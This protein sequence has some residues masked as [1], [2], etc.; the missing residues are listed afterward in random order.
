MHDLG[1]EPSDETKKMLEKVKKNV[2]PQKDVIH[3]MMRF[4]VRAITGV[5]FYWI[6]DMIRNI[7]SKKYKELIP[8]IPKEA[9]ETLA[10][11]QYRCGGTHGE[12]SDA[13][14]IDAVLTFVMLACSGG[15]SIGITIG[16]PEA[17]NQ[18]DKDIINLMTLKTNG[19]MQFS[20]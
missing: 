5:K 3:K 14:L 6:A 10:Y 9:R 4:E 13:R 12:V 1:V 16:N 18:V 20:F 2:P 8:S 17:L 11:L 7:L 19:R 15:D